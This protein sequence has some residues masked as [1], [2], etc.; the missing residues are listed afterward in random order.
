MSIAEVSEETLT[1]PGPKEFAI[2]AVG[3]VKTFGE[4]K[5]VRGVDLRVLKGTI[6]ALLGPNGAGK[7]TTIN[8]LTTLIPP[9]GGKAT[10]AG[11][12]VVRQP[13]EVRRRIG[14][15]FQET[16]M[17][18]T[19][20]GRVLLD[21]HGRL[22]NLQK[23]EIKAR[24]L[25]LVKLVELEEAI[26]RP[27]KTYSGGMKRR[28]EL[29]RGLMTNP[30]VL[31]LDEPTLGLDPQNRDRIWAYIQKLQ[32]EEGLTILITTHYMDE[33]EKLADRVGIIDGGKIVAEGTPTELIGAMGA[34]VVSL[35]GTGQVEDFLANLETQDWV[36]FAHFHPVEETNPGQPLSP[37]TSLS[38]VREVQVGLLGEAGR[39][40]RPII[41]L[42]EKSNF[43]V[44][45]ISINRPG[46]NDVFLKYTGRR[47]RD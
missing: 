32:K 20:S 23:D 26:D 45:D 35:V 40:L 8:M 33:A 22:Y 1:G 42:A 4:V 39:S 18:K 41:E 17:D 44:A 43:K 27:V 14:V 47:L 38:P 16:V 19:L 9:G 2:E 3:L 31:F 36:S 5:A 25:E 21:I 28:L 46:L 30:S 34:D 24:I 37:S 6:Y 29:A 10:V 13:G 15:T 7:T 11:F 12:D